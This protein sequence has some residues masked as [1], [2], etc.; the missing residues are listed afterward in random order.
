[1]Q[2]EFLAISGERTIW[3]FRTHPS[4]NGKCVG[5]CLIFTPLFPLSLFT[6]PW[7]YYPPPAQ[8]S[9]RDRKKSQIKV[10]KSWRGEGEGRCK[11]N[12]RRAT[13]QICGD[14][15]R[16]GDRYRVR[17]GRWEYICGGQCCETRQVAVTLKM[18]VIK[19]TIGRWIWWFWL[20]NQSSVKR[21]TA[22]IQQLPDASWLMPVPNKKKGPLTV[23]LLNL[24]KWQ[25]KC[26]CLPLWPS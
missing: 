9:E 26:S 23:L 15:T 3:G 25:K 2:N 12:N 6:P 24:V 8:S 4:D 17:E 5:G 18:T 11:R 19:V 13:D 7:P 10:V 21:A 16:E 22:Q 1:M 14:R 20:A